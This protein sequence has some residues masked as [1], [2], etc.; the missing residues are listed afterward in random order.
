MF[1]EIPIPRQRVDKEIASLNAAMVFGKE[2]R[3]AMIDHT[4][5]N[6]QQ[7]Q[8]LCPRYPKSSTSVE[9]ISLRCSLDSVLHFQYSFDLCSSDQGSP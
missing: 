4:P 1:G 8:V 3:I 2:K 7:R 5:N 9:V 6:L